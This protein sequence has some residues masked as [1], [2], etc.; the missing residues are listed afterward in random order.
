MAVFPPGGSV[1]QVAR[2]LAQPLPQ[3]LGQAVSVDNRG[4]A[5]GSIGAAFVAKSGAQKGAPRA[6][7]P[8]AASAARGLATLHRG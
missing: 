6:E 2:I 5:S 4:G 8:G 7:A 1:D 3:V